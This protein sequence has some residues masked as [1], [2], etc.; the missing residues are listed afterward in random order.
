MAGLK[1]CPRP[2]KGRCGACRYVDICGGNTRVRAHQ[3][4][5]DPW[6]QDPACYLSDAEIGVAP[7]RAPSDGLARTEWLRESTP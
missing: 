1:S 3:L 5:G 2:L 7:L 6:A 4:T